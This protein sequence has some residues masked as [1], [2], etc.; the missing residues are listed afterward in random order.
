VVPNEHGS[1]SRQRRDF[2]VLSQ[3]DLARSPQ[4]IQRTGIDD[5]ESARWSLDAI[6]DAGAV[7]HVYRPRVR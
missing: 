4:R 7:A 1:R 6:R 5:K 2:T 3:C